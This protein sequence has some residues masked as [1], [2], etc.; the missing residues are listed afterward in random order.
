M[1][2]PGNQ[3]LQLHSTARAEDY[4]RRRQAGTAGEVETS[5]EAAESSPEGSWAL[6]LGCE[7]RRG[8]CRTSGLF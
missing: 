6:E 5:V 1:L 4:A 2:T 3:L 7:G 8:A